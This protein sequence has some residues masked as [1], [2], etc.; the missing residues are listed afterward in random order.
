MAIVGISL[1]AGILAGNVVSGLA[2]PEF[3]RGDRRD[4]QSAL[5][6]PMG[7]QSLGGQSTSG[8]MLGGTAIGG[9]AVGGP[10]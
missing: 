1:A 4:V 8:E 2:R 9:K 7:G 5:G 3:A 10:P 6:A